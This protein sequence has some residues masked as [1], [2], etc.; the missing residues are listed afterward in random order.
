MEIASMST[1]TLALTAA[2][3]EVFEK[4]RNCFVDALGVEP[5]DVVLKARVIDDLGAESLDFLD[6]AYRL[7]QTFKIKIPRGEVKQKSQQGLT[8]T[9]WEKDG[10]LT[11]KALEKLHE[12]MPEVDV[13]YIKPGLKA[14]DI[15]RLFTVETFYN[16]VL[17]LL[18]EKA[19]EVK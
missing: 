9:D 5:E 14:K 1:N 12:V 18:S 8:A 16:M 13:S 19:G 15:P 4:V 2:Q 7:E 17:K 6:I 3:P 10:L 11:A